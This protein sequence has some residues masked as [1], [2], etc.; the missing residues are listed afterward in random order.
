MK[1]SI[2][3]NGMKRYRGLGLEDFVTTCKAV[4]MT[5]KEIIEAVRKSL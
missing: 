5:D 3:F 2:N 4:G 1:K